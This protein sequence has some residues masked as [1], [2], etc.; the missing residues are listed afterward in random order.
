M[1]LLDPNVRD[2]G[3]YSDLPPGIEHGL[4]LEEQDEDEDGYNREV[5]GSSS[6]L[7]P[8][9]DFLA[10]FAGKRNESTS[11]CFCCYVPTST[12]FPLQGKSVCG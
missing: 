8:E 4:G 3:D 11:R 7:A 5:G 9:M 6:S 12:R 1:E 2:W 10:D